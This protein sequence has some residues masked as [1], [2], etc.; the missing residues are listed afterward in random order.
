[1]WVSL[2]LPLEKTTLMPTTG[3]KRRIA[4]THRTDGTD[5]SRSKAKVQT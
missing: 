4:I 3:F 5:W 2:A 1:M